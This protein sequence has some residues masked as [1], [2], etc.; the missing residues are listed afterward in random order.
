M[1]HFISGPSVNLSVNSKLRRGRCYLYL[2]PILTPNKQ[3]NKSFTTEDI[4]SLHI[5]C[6]LVLCLTK[7]VGEGCRSLSPECVYDRVS[8][9]ALQDNISTPAGRHY[10]SLMAGGPIWR[11]L[12]TGE[13]LPSYSGCS[14]ALRVEKTQSSPWHHLLLQAEPSHSSFWSDGVG[15]IRLRKVD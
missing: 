2:P 7:K 3:A 1:T 12:P 13:A 10:Q 14:H 9:T 5:E 4:P 11:S 6:H 15:V 8:A